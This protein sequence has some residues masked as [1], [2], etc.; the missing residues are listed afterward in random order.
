[1]TDLCEAMRSQ[2]V[3]PVLR[4]PSA[5]QA[6]AAA[7]AMLEMGLGVV[8]L[9]ATTPGW[10]DALV[11]VLGE[12]PA[13]SWVGMG[14]M[15]SADDA[16]R[17]VDSGAQF[18]V[19]PWPVPGVREVAD[20]AGVVV[21][22]GGFTPAEVA[23]AVRQGPAKLFPAHVGGPTYLR[24][25]RVVLP[26]GAFV[27]P[28]GGITLDEVPA[29]LDAGAAAVGVGGDLLA[30]GA[31]DHLRGVLERTAAQRAETVA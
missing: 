17:A 19:T 9:T 24:S 25:L 11:A 28:T 30:P 22:E 6:R 27:V 12:A 2:Q 31:T 23:A 15:R 14:T 5:D 21:L 8:E 3:L 16:R 29:W 1:M 10:P 4:L 7:A 18:L 20:A 26:D 13:G